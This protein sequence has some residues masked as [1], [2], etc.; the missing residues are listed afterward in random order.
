MSIRGE[1]QLLLVVV[2]YGGHY[3]PAYHHLDIRGIL[4]ARTL[5]HPTHFIIII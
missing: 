4:G 3:I 1:R 5:F 2:V